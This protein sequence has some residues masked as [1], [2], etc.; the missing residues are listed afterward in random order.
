MRFGRDSA[1]ALSA[2]QKRLAIPAIP[3]RIKVT[4]TKTPANIN[5]YLRTRPTELSRVALINLR[6]RNPKSNIGIL[7]RSLRPRA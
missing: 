1:A 7:C 2:I 3:H 5:M 4:N 6:N